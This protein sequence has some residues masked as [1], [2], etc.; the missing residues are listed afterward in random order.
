[1]IFTTFRTLQ[2]ILENLV[3]LMVLT[4]MSTLDFFKEIDNIKV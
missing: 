1:M 4:T 3:A 2:K